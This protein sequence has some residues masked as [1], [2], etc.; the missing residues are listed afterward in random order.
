VRLQQASAAEQ[1]RRVLAAFLI[2]R[3]APLPPCSAFLEIRESIQ[4]LDP[5]LTPSYLEGSNV[6]LA[7]SCNISNPSCL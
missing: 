5:T 6:I 2:M 1:R 4:D 7:A 3:R